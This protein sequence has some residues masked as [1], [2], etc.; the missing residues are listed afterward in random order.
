MEKKND[1]LAQVGLGAMVLFIGCLIAITSSMYVMITQ[2]EIITQST[3][4][5]VSTTSKEA[6]TQILF[7]GAWIDDAYD[8]YLFMIEYQSLGKEVNIEDVGWVLWCVDA[9]DNHHRRMGHLGDNLASAQGATIWEVGE[10]WDNEPD[11]LESGKRYFVNTDGGTGT[12]TTGS[13]GQCGP[14]HIYD[15]GLTAYYTIYLPFGGHSTQE[16]RI[17]NYGVGE[18]VT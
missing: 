17:T 7:V 2:L 1:N 9:A 5:V 13:G 6:H 16:L 12:G 8:D 11:T 15:D 14:S 10:T 18:S 4:K 3:E